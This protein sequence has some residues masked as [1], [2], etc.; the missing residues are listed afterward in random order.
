MEGQPW[1]RGISGEEAGERQSRSPAS[2]ASFPS[3]K[4]EEFIKTPTGD[5]FVKSS[6]RKGLLP[7]I[8]ENLLSARKRLALQPL[9]WLSAQVPMVTQP[10]LL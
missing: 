2:C 6:V 7:Q 10:C 8:L 4:P 9:P 3:L 5:E 1:G